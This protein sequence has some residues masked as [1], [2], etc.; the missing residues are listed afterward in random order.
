MGPDLCI[1]RGAGDLATGVLWRMNRAGWPAIACELAEPLTVR[2]TVSFSSAIRQGEVEVQG[3]HALRC[4]TFDE[5]VVVARSGRV[6]V[7][8]S[9]GLP[10]LPGLRADVVVDARLAKRNIDTTLDDAALVVGLGPGFT[11]GLDCHAIVETQ[12][13]HDLGRVL[14]AGSAAP[15]TGTPGVVGGRGA[16]RVLRATLDGTVSWERSIGD[17]VSTGEVLGDVG[18]A[19]LVAPFDGVVRGLIADGQTVPAGLKVGD[20][21]PRAD[22]HACTTISDKALAIGGGVLEAVLTW[23]AG[24]KDDRG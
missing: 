10:R 20:I 5:A 22:A 19:E 21:D 11:A 8:V 17:V 1:V 12:R 23:A 3:V 14:W 15:N 4:T 7:I 18:G 9:P 16:E 2:R 6:A 24:N 13:G